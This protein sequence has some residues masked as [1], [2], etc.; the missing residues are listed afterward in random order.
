MEDK[1]VQFHGWVAQQPLGDVDHPQGRWESL[2]KRRLD[3]IEKEAGAGL[4]GD[5]QAELERIQEET[6]R[7]LN[8]VAPLPFELLER[9]EE[10]ARRAGVRLDDEEA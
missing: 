2:N 6:G 8:A 10:R 4:S 9:F 7:Y 1:A 5:E 3:L